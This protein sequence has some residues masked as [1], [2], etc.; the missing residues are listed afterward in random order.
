MGWARP[1]DIVALIDDGESSAVVVEYAGH[2]LV[3][4]P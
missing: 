3:A 1:Y 2:D 4:Y